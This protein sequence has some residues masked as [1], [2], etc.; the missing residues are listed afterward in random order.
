MNLQENGKCVQ[1]QTPHS[2]MAT[3]GSLFVALSLVHL[4]DNLEKV[5]VGIEDFKFQNFGRF[6]G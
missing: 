4:D 2:S 6:L 5:Y 1:F 3:G